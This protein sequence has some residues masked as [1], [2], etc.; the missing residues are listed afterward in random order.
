VKSFPALVIVLFIAVLG[1][2]GTASTGL[3]SFFLVIVPY[4]ALALFVIGFLIRLIGWSRAPVPFHI[5]TVAGQQK[6]L[7]WIKASRF[8]SPWT[9]GGLIGRLLMEVVLFRSLWRNDRVEL[10]GGG[11]LV[12]GSRRYLWLAAILFHWSLAVILFRHLR[13][14][15][16][17]V[18]SGVS[19]IESLDGFFQVNLTPLYLTDVLIVLGLGFLLLRRFFASQVRFISLLQ[20]Y[21]AVFLLFTIALSGVLMRY[22]F[23][24]DLVGIKELVVGIVSF[25]PRTLQSGGGS[26]LAGIHLLSVSVL[27]GYFPFSKLMH[28]PGVF[29]SPTR[30]LKNDSRT[31]RHVNPLNHAVK[32]H[33]YEE[34]E[35]DFRS[36]MIEAGLPVERNE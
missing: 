6:S 11:K 29:L 31:V 20:D 22:F 34:Y 21:F 32:T 7:E 15:T 24:P 35:D 14:F 10:K 33:T 4:C 3:S 30:N 36:A 5:P 23:H 28:A 19:F 25:S 2:A 18:M 16:D 9:T 1:A 27:V 13:F 17:P 26:W 12:F 8:E